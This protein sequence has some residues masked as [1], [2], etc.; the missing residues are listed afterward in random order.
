[1]IDSPNHYALSKRVGEMV[2]DS[3]VV[4]YP[5]MGITSL[6]INL[7]I[8]PEQLA[9]L[10]S[11]P[12]RFPWGHSN[13]WAYVD[14]RDASRA[15]L[16]AINKGN[17]GHAVY[18]VAADDT[19]LWRPT[20]DAIQEHFGKEIS[21]EENLPEFG[22]TVNCEKIKRELGWSPQFTWRDEAQNEFEG[23]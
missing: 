20:R 19:I 11:D 13:L 17:R 16:A 4:K 5:E 1:M 6:R 14:A 21:F 9:D 3:M 12:D 10:R 8:M 15:A 7:V 2:A 22:S 23:A 18:M